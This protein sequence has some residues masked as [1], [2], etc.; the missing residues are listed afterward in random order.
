MPKSRRVLITGSNRGIGLGTAIAYAERDDHVFAVCRE[1]S[2]DLEGLDVEIVDDVELT[3]DHSVSV[4]R[5]RVGDEGI[6]VLI[7]NAGINNDSP[8]LEDID[9]DNLATA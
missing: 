2:P 1:P 9:V 6:D 8:G 5:D 7:C 4:L 3:D